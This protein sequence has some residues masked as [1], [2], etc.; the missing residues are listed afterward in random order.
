MRHESKMEPGMRATTHPRPAGVT[1][2]E[3]T[4]GGRVGGMAVVG[5]HRTYAL[6]QRR[7]HLPCGKIFY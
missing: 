7:Q 4:D 6:R 2:G 3:G 1:S 5:Y